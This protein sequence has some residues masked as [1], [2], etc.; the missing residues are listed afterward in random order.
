MGDVNVVHGDPQE[1]GSDL[2]HELAND[3]DGKLVGAGKG[4]SVGAE[5]VH[6]ELQHAAQLLELKFIADDLRRVER[7][8]VVVAEEVFVVG[9]AFGGR[10][11][12]VLGKNDLRALAETVGA[13]AAFADAVE[14]V[15]GGDN[16]GV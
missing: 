15:A 8:L 16:P 1:A 2:T 3:I 13:M 9:A 11:Q 7:R 4:Q 6:R 14:A 12:Q 10:G 5:V